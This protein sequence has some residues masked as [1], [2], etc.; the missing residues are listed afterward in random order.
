ML[1]RDDSSHSKNGFGTT[2]A[3]GTRRLAEK[4]VTV[5]DDIPPVNGIA[6][7]PSVYLIMAN[8][9]EYV[10]MHGTLNRYVY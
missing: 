9:T 3:K 2:A 8:P 6:I 4:P 5:G 10:N 1:F 7:N